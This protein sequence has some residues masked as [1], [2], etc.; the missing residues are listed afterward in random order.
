MKMFKSYQSPLGYTNGKNNIDSY[1]VD[2][3]QF[4]TQDELLYQNA[5]Q[6]RENQLI[7][8]Y[9][10]HGITDNYPQSG[11]GFWGNADDNYGFGNSQ[12]SK[13]VE[14]IE[15]Q[16]VIP[17]YWTTAD[18]GKKV[19]NYVQQREGNVIPE[20]QS[21]FD[22]GL[23]GILAANNMIKNKNELAPLPYT[24]KYKHALINC[25]AAQYGNGGNDMSKILSFIKEAKDVVTFQNTLDSSLADNYANKVGRLLGTKYPQGNCE[26]MVSKY[27]NQYYK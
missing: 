27:I 15:K 18:E 4:S 26:N 8:S 3:S 16:P 14:N 2:H 13:N 21:P 7:K 1:G 17:Q 11:P 6:N 23:S 19:F 25:E 22:Y 10:S 5:R 20:K 24:D 12:I 9:N